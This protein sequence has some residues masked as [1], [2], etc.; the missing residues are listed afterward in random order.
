[1][2]SNADSICLVWCGWWWCKCISIIRVV[3]IVSIDGGGWV[4]CQMFN[5][6][7]DFCVGKGWLLDIGRVIFI[8]GRVVVIRRPFHEGYIIHNGCLCKHI[9]LSIFRVGGGVGWLICLWRWNE[10]YCFRIGGRCH[11]VVRKVIFI[12][13]RVIFV[14]QPTKMLAKVSP[15]S[16]ADVFE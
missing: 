14:E 7:L 12:S 3:D 16:I 2:K 10:Y 4:V 15:Q 8:V 11:L 9:I 1:M 5:N 13:G 6:F